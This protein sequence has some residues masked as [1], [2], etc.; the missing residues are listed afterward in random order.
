LLGEGAHTLKGHTLTRLAKRE[1]FSCDGDFAILGFPD[2][3]GFFGR[4][5]S[6]SEYGVRS[7]E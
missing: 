2:F 1:M 6:F 5:T 7:E 3:G 4:H